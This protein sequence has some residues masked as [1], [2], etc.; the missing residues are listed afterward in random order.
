MTVIVVM[1]MVVIVP[2]VVPMVVMV[3]SLMAAVLVVHMARLAMSRIEEIGLQLG[4]PRQVEGSPAEDQLQRVKQK[5][6]EELADRAR[7]LGADGIVGATL[8]FSQF[9]AV[10]FLCAACGTA[11]KVG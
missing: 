9:D 3:V 6:F 11:V 5:A 4:D 2:M 1:T 10:V 7:A 8:Q